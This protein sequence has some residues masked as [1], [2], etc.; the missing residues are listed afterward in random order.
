MNARH[1][2]LT[3][4]LALACLWDSSPAHT[5]TAAAQES[6]TATGNPGVPWPAT[7]AL[8][9]TVPLAETVGALRTNRFVGIFYFLWH[10]N[11]GGKRPDGDGPYDIARILAQDPKAIEKP[12]SPLWGP[13]GMYHYWG[14]PLYGYYLSTDRWV[15][16]R[17]AQLLADAGID[18]LIFDATNALTYREQYT[19]L[20]E[21]FLEVRR[22]GGRAPYI[23]F[24]VNTEAGATA[25]RLY[26]ELYQPGLHR[27]LWFPWEGKPLLICDPAQAA[28]ELRQFFTLR[29]AH[30]P[31]EM[32]NTANAW[33]WE[34][35]YPQPYG[36]TDHPD[37]P[38]QVNVSVAQNLRRQDG[39]VT[40]MSSGEARGRSFHQGRMETA[41]GAVDRGYNFQ[42]QWQRAFDLNPPFVMVTGWNEWIAGR[43]GKADGPLVFV[44]QFTQ[45]YSRDIE[46]TR[47]SHGDNYYWQ[48]VA[49]VRR[50]KG[51][52]PLPKASPPKSIRLE[53]DFTQWQDVMPEFADHQGETAPRDFD[54]AGG[55]HY[56]N[57]TGRNDLDRFKVARDDQTL[58]FYARTRA[59]LT[60]ASDANWM[61]LLLDTDLDAATGWL[62]CDFLVN[63]ERAGAGEAWLE[64]NTGG[65]TWQRVA[66]VRFR[67][68]GPHLHLA[69]PRQALGLE[70]KGKPLTLDF[71]WA[72]NWQHPEDPLDSYVSGDTAPEGRFLFRYR[73]D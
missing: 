67:A 62:G 13:V 69:I 1:I 21:V 49:N 5:S 73:A 33:H 60:P 71:K 7:D 15:L 50:Y 53:G 38:E 8:G 36:F 39:K 61:W 24:M 29:R 9:R 40:N 63:R 3:A 55:T 48:L 44:D 34:A 19:A 32:V 54:G 26:R 56:T 58:Y 27:E 2:L 12:D 65:W 51:T 22:E 70:A 23:A 72:D 41:P 16:R 68:E 37:R 31:F 4:G 18:V 10:N 28:A 66:K 11:R 57:H 17:H 20:C 42:E 45:E 25:Q 6:R 14:E 52:A 35:T 46:P 43:W 59:P 30:W 64:K 47:A